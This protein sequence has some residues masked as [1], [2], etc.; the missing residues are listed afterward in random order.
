MIIS[1]I[2]PH[3]CIELATHPQLCEIDFWGK[4]CLEPDLQQ[5]CV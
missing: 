3:L 1:F 4:G 2:P 5:F